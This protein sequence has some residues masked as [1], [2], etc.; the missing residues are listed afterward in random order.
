LGIYKTF[1]T[2]MSTIVT[3]LGNYIKLTK[4]QQQCRVIFGSSSTEA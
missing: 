2:V 4:A 3:C 1:V